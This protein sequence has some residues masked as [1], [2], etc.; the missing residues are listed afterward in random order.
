MNVLSID[1]GIKNLACCSLYV[2]NNDYTINSWDVIDLCETKNEKCLCLNK[3]GSVCNNKGIYHKNEVYYCKKHAE[4]S[5]YL[6]PCKELTIKKLKKKKIQE[7]KDLCD[8]F[9]ITVISPALKNNIVLSIE[10]YVNERCLEKVENTN[11]NNMDLITIGRKI[12]ELLSK[13]YENS[14]DIVLIENQISPIANRMKTIQGMICQYFIM[15]NAKM[16]EFVSSINKLKDFD[17]G[18]STSYSERKKKSISIT[19]KLLKED[20][21]SKIFDKSKKKDDLA[22]CFLQGLWYLKDKNIII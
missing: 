11:A 14:F 16:I 9:N 18:K 19:K 5:N 10:N 13:K 1:V 7:L 8:K 15:N 3:N 21:S 4:L 12:N 20:D 22:D 2:D 6:I 17:I